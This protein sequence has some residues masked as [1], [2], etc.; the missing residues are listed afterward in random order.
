MNPFLLSALS[1]IFILT[2][3]TGTYVLSKRYRFPYTVALVA[4]GAV[5]ALAAT[6]IPALSFVDDFRLTPDVLLYVFLPILLFESAYNIRY[7][8]LLKNS[9]SVSL[10]AVVSLVISAVAVGYGLKFVLGLMGVEVP[11]MATLLFGA[12]ISATDPV[13]VLA[14]FKEL[15]APKRLTLVFEGESLFNDGTALALFLV[16]LAIAQGPSTDAGAVHSLFSA[17]THHLGFGTLLTGTLSFASM[18]VVGMAFGGAVGVLF[19]KAIGKLHNEPLLELSLTLAL[20]HATFAASE[21]VTHFVAPTSGVIATT[22]A[23]MV[24]GNYGRLK[25]TPS[26][27]KTMGHYWEFFAFMANSF[28]FVLIGV[29]VVELPIDWK[30]FLLPTLAAVGVVMVA[31]ALSVYPV[32]GLLNLTKTEERIPASWQHLLSWGSLRGALAIIMVLLIPEN[33]ALEGWTLPMGV[34]DFALALTVGCIVFT[35]FVKA[36]TIFP[37]MRK[38][39]LVGF[40]K[41]ERLEYLKGKYRV[42]IDSA[43]KLERMRTEGR[44]PEE[45]T[46]LLLAKQAREAEA[47]EASIKRAL[48]G[49]AEKLRKT[50][51][52]IVSRHAFG[53]EKFW[54]K[55]LYARREITETLLK[56]LLRKIARQTERIEAGLPALDGDGTS[57]DGVFEK[58]A[59]AL[60][61]WGTGRPDATVEDYLKYRAREIVCERVVR[62]IAELERIPFLKDSGIVDEIGERYRTFGAKAQS[63]RKSLFKKH[64]DVLLSLDSRLADKAVS[65]AELRALEALVEKDVLP[66]KAATKLREEIEERLFEKIV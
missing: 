38:F 2:A 59:D 34:R 43:S 24:L 36:T 11:I 63:V 7:R 42:L 39:D 66:Q 49:D 48:S 21:L 47:T 10:L 4:M 5:L 17:A 51:Y 3:A 31:R 16:I 65:T 20:A 1:A 22:V 57:G 37:M 61:A 33:L 44:I 13:A 32:I 14:L 62:D 45:E 60:D 26:V 18:I 52:A 55:E 29:L 12:L 58:F 56:K 6:K 23:A 46:E 35:T 64:K 40:G 53:L 54:L 27:E 30:F 19:S 50:L 28:V 25:I 15:G 9:K 8:E 41:E